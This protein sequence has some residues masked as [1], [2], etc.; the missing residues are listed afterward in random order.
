MVIIFIL[1]GFSQ[2][3]KGFYSP[4]AYKLTKNSI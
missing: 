3:V 4:L 2:V 1:N